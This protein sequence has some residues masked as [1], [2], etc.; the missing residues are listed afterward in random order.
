MSGNVSEWCGPSVAV[1]GGSW[2]DISLYCS[3][4]GRYDGYI[5][6]NEL[7]NQIGF[8]ILLEK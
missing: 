5:D 7:N 8:R 2:N 6:D 3:S 4:L 1:R